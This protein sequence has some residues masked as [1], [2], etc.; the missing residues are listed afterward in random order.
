MDKELAEKGLSA[1]QQQ[2]SAERKSEKMTAQPEGI[3]KIDSAF[4]TP[5]MRRE[6]AQFVKLVGSIRSQFRPNKPQV[7][8]NE[9]GQ[10]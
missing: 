9:S 3:K 4:D 7:L 6:I 10:R 8:D 2:N 5:E 1:D